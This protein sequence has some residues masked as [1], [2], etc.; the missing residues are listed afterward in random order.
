M[1]MQFLGSSQ[2]AHA[3][4]K[5]DQSKIMISMQMRNENMAYFTAFQF[6]FGEL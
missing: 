5:S 6:V 2:Q 4:Q 3:G 1:Q